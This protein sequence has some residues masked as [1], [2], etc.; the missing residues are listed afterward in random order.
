MGF[1]SWI[2]VIWGVSLLIVLLCF[3]ESVRVQKRD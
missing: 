2:A 3:W 1:W